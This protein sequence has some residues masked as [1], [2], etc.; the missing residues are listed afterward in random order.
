MNYRWNITIM[1]LLLERFYLKDFCFKSAKK[2]C[3]LYWF[4]ILFFVASVF[5][6]H[7]YTQILSFKF[8]EFNPSPNKNQGRKAKKNVESLDQAFPD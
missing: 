5:L 4:I 6:S 3:F 1:L 7:S 8:S 2:N